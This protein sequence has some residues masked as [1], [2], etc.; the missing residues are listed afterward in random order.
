MVYKLDTP[1]YTRKLRDEENEET[2]NHV[3]KKK[4]FN[5]S[6]ERSDLH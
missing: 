1:L 5:V 3:L 6:K 4:C 2:Q